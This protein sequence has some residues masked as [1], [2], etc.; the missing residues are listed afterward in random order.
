MAK[1]VRITLAQVMAILALMGILLSAVGTAW[2][3]Q[4]P[5]S[6]SP[7]VIMSGENIP[8]PEKN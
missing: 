4:L 1:K 6:S 3:S 7:E 8:T 2:I 5:A